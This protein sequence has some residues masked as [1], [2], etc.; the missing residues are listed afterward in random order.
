MPAGSPAAPCARGS[1]NQAWM[2]SS[3]KKVA[4]TATTM[5]GITATPLN[6]STSRTCRRDARRAAPPL[7]PHPREPARPARAQQQQHDE[8][9]EHQPERRVRLAP[10]ASP[11][12]S[13]TK[14]AMPSTSATAARISVTRLAE[15]QVGDAAQ[16]SA[17]RGHARGADRGSR[18]AERRDVHCAAASAAPARSGDPAHDRDLQVA[19]L[20]AQRVAV[21]SQHRRRLDLVAA[22][23][24]QRQS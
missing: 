14:V 12:A 23:R 5:A 2:P 1:L 17:A 10:K 24:R 22:R 13:T 7:H 20:L 8:V 3:K 6:S 9:G 16:A 18:V 19:D 4:N 21:Q 11:P 15:Q